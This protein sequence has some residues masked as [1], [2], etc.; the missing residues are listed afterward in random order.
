MLSIFSIFVNSVLNFVSQLLKSLEGGPVCKQPEQKL[1][2]NTATVLY[3]GRIP[4]G[5][6]EKEMEGTHGFCFL[7][8]R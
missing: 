3:V 5:F 1:L 8:F 2:K 6:Y 7:K 4:H